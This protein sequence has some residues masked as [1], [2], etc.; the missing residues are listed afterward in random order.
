[1]RRTSVL[2]LLWTAVVLL[3]ILAEFVVQIKSVYHGLW[4]KEDE[5]RTLGP[6]FNPYAPQRSFLFRVTQKKRMFNLHRDA[7]SVQN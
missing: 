4:V 2:V 5:L 7:F 3:H 1:M 6:S